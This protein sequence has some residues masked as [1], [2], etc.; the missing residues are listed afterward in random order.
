MC[1]AKYD[2]AKKKK[3]SHRIVL[4]SILCLTALNNSSQVDNRAELWSAVAGEVSSRNQYVQPSFIFISEPT[5][6]HRQCYY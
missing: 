6:Q 2:L 4:V 3:L 1:E 5:K